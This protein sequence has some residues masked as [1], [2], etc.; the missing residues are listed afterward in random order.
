MQL[1]GGWEVGLLA[2]M[3]L[4]YLGGA[5]L[6]PAF[7]GTTDAFQALLR[8]TARFGVMAVGMTFVIVNKDID[9]SVGSTFGLDRRRLR[10]RLQHRALRHG[11]RSRRS[12]S[13]SSLGAAIGLDQRRAGHRPPGARLHRHAD[14]AADR[15][16]LRPRPDRRAVDPLSASRRATTTGSSRSARPTR[17][18]FNNQ[19]IIALVIV[20][21]GAI[22]LAKTRWGYETL[23]TGGNEQAAIYAG[24][25]TNWVRI[26]AYILSSLCATVAG[27]MTVAQDKGI[28]S[29]AGLLAELIVIAAVII[30]GASHPRRARPR[31]RQL[32]SARCWSALIHKVLR[33]GLPITRAGQGRRTAI[34]AGQGD[35]HAA[36]GRGAGLHRHAADP[37]GADRALHHPPQAPAAALGVAPRPAAAARRP[38]AGGVAIEGAQT[39][40][41]RPPTA[42]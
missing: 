12:S 1:V 10:L 25:P 18:G 35:L 31:D 22:V 36:G 21:I 5:I 2:L 39:R 16:R 4:L 32:S 37:R 11:R 20:A 19:I 42:R 33:E 15:A 41:R 9:L 27:L 34:V 7:F 3:A 23:A 30:G 26:R 24:I 8:D 6:N 13:A 28:T 38:T 14:H 29:Q 40:A 17:S